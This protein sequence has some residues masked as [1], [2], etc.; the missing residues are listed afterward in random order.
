MRLKLFRST[1]HLGQP[2]AIEESA[3]RAILAR[4]DE[5]ERSFHAIAREYGDPID[6]AWSGEIQN[7]VAVIPVSGVLM[8]QLSFWGWFSGSSTY[9]VLI[10]DIQGG[11]VASDTIT[12][13]TNFSGSVG[14]YTLDITVPEDVVSVASGTSSISQPNFFACGGCNCSRRKRF[15]IHRPPELEYLMTQEPTDNLVAYIAAS[16][17]VRPILSEKHGR[18]IGSDELQNALCRVLGIGELNSLDLLDHSLTADK[19]LELLKDSDFTPVQ[20]LYTVELSDEDG[21]I[22]E[23]TTLVLLEKVVKVKGEKWE[24]HRYDADPWPSN[25]HAHNYAS[26]LKMHLGTGELFDNNRRSKGRIAAKKLAAIR[27]ELTAAG[28][29]LPS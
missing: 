9:E 27:E 11:T 1:S 28:I 19:M 8:R 25:P 10:K 12:N 18:T 20:V 3:M 23:Y 15:T 29:T 26:R 6:G 7:G 14:A 16:E 4:A 17:K 5:E 22:P 24:I 2:W 13:W 21:I